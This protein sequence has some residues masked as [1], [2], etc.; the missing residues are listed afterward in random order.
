MVVAIPTVV[1]ASSG[2]WVD[3]TS[4]NGTMWG[5]SSEEFTCDHVDW[6][7]KWKYEPTPGNSS[8]LPVRFKFNVVEVGAQI[9]EFFIPPTGQIAGTL[10]INQTGT[11]Y[12]DVD[13]IYV[14]NYSILVEQ[15]VD[16]VP[17][18]PSWIILPFILTCA[19]IVVIYKKK[20]P[21]TQP[22]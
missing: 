10:Y 17:E 9:I 11:F 15:N 21:K 20:L 18:F 16:S 6:R 13:T 5:G 8:V 12:I 14:E 7:I 19:F 2:N 4:F 1:F 3:V 22:Y